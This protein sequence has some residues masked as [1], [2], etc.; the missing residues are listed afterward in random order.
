MHPCNVH[1]LNIFDPELQHINTK[2][3]IKT[4]KKN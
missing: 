2:E 1:I 4:K 3:M